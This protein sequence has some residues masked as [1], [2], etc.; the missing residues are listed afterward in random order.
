MKEWDIVE[1]LLTDA[2]ELFKQ[3]D[4]HEGMMRLAEAR[5]VCNAFISVEVV[6]DLAREDYEAGMP[7]RQIALKR[8]IPV[9]QITTRAYDQEWVNPRKIQ[10]Q[11][12]P[13]G[14]RTLMYLTCYKCEQKFESAS[15]SKKV[16]DVC[17]AQVNEPK[18]RQY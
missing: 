1:A 11:L 14:K 3:K 10:S 9:R 8:N 5:G 6:W 15:G 16:C 7:P 13:V 12:R 2:I 4:L 18:T 17:R